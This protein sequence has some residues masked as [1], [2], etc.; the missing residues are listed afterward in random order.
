[1]EFHTQGIAA[2]GFLGFL[3]ADALREAKLSQVPA[4]PGVYMVLRDSVEPQAFA[5]TSCGGHFKGKNPTVENAVLEG[6]WVHGATVLYI[7]KAGGGTPSATL[8]ERLGAFLNSVKAS[9][10][11]IGAVA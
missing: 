8:R 11:H 6:K 1:M 10:S 3:T 5:E 7:G 2:A 4:Q 9:Q